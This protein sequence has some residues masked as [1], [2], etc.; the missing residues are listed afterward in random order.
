[1][2]T[3]GLRWRALRIA[4]PGATGATA[5]LALALVLAAALALRVGAVEISTLDLVRAALGPDVELPPALRDVRLPRVACGALVGAAL[6]VAGAVLQT[7]LRNPLADAGIV[8]VTAGAGLAA[9]VAILFFPAL[10]ALVPVLAFAGGLAAVALVVALG[11]R[12]G[13]LR[14]GPLRLVLSGVAVQAAG[15]AGIALLTFLYA[16]RAPAFTAFLVG[17][18]NG[19]GW[20]EVELVAA[21]AALGLLAAALAT[22][23]LDVLLLDDA[24]AGGLGVAVRR[25]RFLAAALAA[26]LAAAAVSVAGLVGFVGLVV[27]NGLRLLVGPGHRA[28]LPASALGGAA[29]VLLADAAARTLAAPV[30]LPVGALLALLGGPYFLFVLW[31]KLP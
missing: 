20:N 5:L 27:P 11:F 25:A 31:R 23:P 21:P 15:F 29:L 28:L 9:L 2:S 17:S 10:P 16:D 24:S 6:A 3:L 4:A 18:L 13:G 1:M 12:H 19:R 8:G 14:T 26:W 22:R 30:E 7:A